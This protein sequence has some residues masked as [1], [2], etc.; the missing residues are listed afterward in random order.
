MPKKYFNQ[1]DVII[2]DECHLFKAKSLTSIMTKATETK[3][4]IGTTGTL[5]GTDTH[6]LILEGLF[7]PVKQITT[8]QKLIKDK[9]LSDFRI[10]VLTLRYPEEERKRLVRSKYQAEVDYIVSH[11]KRNNFIRNLTVSL[12]GNTLVLFQY[13]EKHG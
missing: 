3:H 7:G 11:S 6:Q 5:D 10:K 1:F 13:V 9:Q 8:T 2:G 12:E 4:R